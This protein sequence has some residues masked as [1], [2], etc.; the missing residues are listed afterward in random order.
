[1]TFTADNT[2]PGHQQLGTI[3]L[4]SVQAYPTALDR[5]NGTNV[6]SGCGSVD[7]GN[8]ANVGARDFYMQDVVSNQDFGP[9]AG[10]QAVVAH[11][12][13]VMNNLSTSQDACKSAFLKLN[14]ST[15]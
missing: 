9:S 7:P 12:T 15:R 3:Y 8:A 6:I 14:L 13:L 2:S 4:A 5:T 11:G 1:M 10:P